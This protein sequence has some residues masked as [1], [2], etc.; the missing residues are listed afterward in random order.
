[1]YISEKST[2]NIPF[3]FVCAYKMAKEYTPLN[4]SAMENF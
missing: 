3:S 4:S 1:M 2:I